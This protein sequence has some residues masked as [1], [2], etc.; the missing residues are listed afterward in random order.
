MLLDLKKTLATRRKKQNNSFGFVPRGLKTTDQHN[1]CVANKKIKLCRLYYS[2]K[3]II[4]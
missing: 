2:I 3:N 1:Y 4:A